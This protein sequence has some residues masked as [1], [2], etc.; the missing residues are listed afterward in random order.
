MSEVDLEEFNTAL[1]G[2]T[3]RV[4]DSNEY[5]RLCEIS[6]RHPLTQRLRGLE[7]FSETYKATVLQLYSDLRGD[8]LDY[9]PQR[10]EQSGLSL[11]QNLWS[12]AS[13]WSFRDSTF[14]AEFLLSWGQI[15]RAL[16]LP[17]G[18]DAKILEYGSG[19]GQL[20]LFLARLGLRMSAVDIDPAS[21][22]LVR[23]QAAAMQ[24]D[25]RTEQAAF[26]DGFGDETFDRIIFFESF[27]HAIDFGP[28]LSRLRR[29]LN[30]G[31]TLILCGEPVVS[32]FVPEVPYPWGPRL[33]GL[34]VFSIRRHG[35]MELGFTESFLIEAMHRYGWLVDVSALPSCGRATSYVAKPYVGN[36]IEVGRQ[37]GLGPHEAGWEGR[38]GTHRWTR[39]DEMATFPLPDK[40]GPSSVK[41]LASN[42]FPVDINVTLFDGDQHVKEVAVAPGSDRVE[43]L[44]GPCLHARFGMKAAGHC[45]SEI[46]PSSGDNRKLG[47]MIHGIKVDPI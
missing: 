40:D 46:W 17:A 16:A 43:I 11:P 26:G 39:G 35:W 12:G 18:S 20:L 14:V 25:V 30:P 19:S 37:I 33:D 5:Q 36:M 28:L 47:L 15:M 34:S 24:L 41:V 31:G 44:F 23:A 7:P 4:P 45:P 27:H 32:A 9:D 29:R 21:L 10:D 38:E 3:G 22:E 13:P 8:D 2:F 6:L 1:S 42:P